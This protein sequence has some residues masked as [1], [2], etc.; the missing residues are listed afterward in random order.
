MR[1]AIFGTI[2]L[3]AA[4]VGFYVMISTSIAKARDHRAAT[5]VERFAPVMPSSV[6]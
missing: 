4:S 6:R 3:A 2:L 1:K 5:F